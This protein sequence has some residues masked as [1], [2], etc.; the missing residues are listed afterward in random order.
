MTNEERERLKLRPLW[1]DSLSK[2]ERQDVGIVVSRRKGRIILSCTTA[3]RRRLLELA[4][5]DMNT[6]DWEKDRAVLTS[7]RFLVGKL[8]KTDLLGKLD[9]C[10][11]CGR[12]LLPEKNDDG[13]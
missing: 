3:E 8:Q 5:H 13:E 2:N 9:T 4:L 10:P 12:D 6:G 11:M 1:F 7:A